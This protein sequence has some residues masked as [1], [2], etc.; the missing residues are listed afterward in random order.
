MHPILLMDGIKVKKQYPSVFWETVK[1]TVLGVWQI[2]SY[3]LIYVGMLF[4]SALL[5]SLLLCFQI[6]E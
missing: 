1:T 5:H 2:K 3:M 6:Q 4:I